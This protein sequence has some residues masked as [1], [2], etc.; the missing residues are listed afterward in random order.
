M[1]GYNYYIIWHNY[2]LAIPSSNFCKSLMLVLL[3]F[4]GHF[5]RIP[6]HKCSPRTFVREDRRSE[7]S[8]P[9]LQWILLVFTMSIFLLVFNCN[10]I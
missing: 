9:Q 7:A 1:E 5:G 4:S 8:P 3:V 6:M 10:M 2:I